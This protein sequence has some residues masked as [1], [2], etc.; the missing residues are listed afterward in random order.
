MARDNRIERVKR[1]PKPAHTQREYTTSDRVH[2]L[3]SN[4]LSDVSQRL[5]KKRTQA[6]K[7]RSS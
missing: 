7:R 5:E 4:V 2:L 3:V 6:D 1:A